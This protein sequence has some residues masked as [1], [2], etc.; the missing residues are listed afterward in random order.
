MGLNNNAKIIAGIIKNI[1]NKSWNCIIKDCNNDAINSHLIPR[2]GILKTLVENGHIYQVKRKDI[3]QLGQKTS[4]FEFKKIGN[5]LSMSHSIF[6]SYHDNNLFRDIDQDVIDL[7]NKKSWLLFSYRA[8]CAELRKKE[9]GKELMFRI[10]RC[11]SL[12]LI[13]I[14]KAKWMHEGFSMGCNDL[15]K[16]MELTEDDLQHNSNNFKFSHFKFPL[17]EICASSLFSFQESSH[18]V[19]DIRNL[20]IMNGGVVHILPQNGFTHVIFG[21][22]EKHSNTDMI[23]FI[24][25]WGNINNK[26]FERKMTELLCA[27]IEDWCMSPRLY[28]KIPNDKITTLIKTLTNNVFADDK[29]IFVDFNLFS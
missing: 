6:C 8:I 5:K 18:N 2:N 16:Y 28:N 25:S 17:L 7:E 1:Q 9:M 24:N 19:E 14:D 20:E 26:E 13:T 3:F 21:Y 29:S 10:M 12:P 15:R 22:D 11:H 4:P 23:D 27:R